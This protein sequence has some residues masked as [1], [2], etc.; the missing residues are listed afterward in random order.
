VK[1]VY[2]VDAET[3]TGTC[4]VLIENKERALIAN[5]A[6]GKFTI[7][8]LRENWAVVEAA[9]F[10]YSAGFF[11]TV[12]PESIIEVGKH[13]QEHGKDYG[14]NLSAPFLVQF[15]KDQMMSCLPYT[16]YLWGN[17]LEAR[18]FA[19][20]HELGTTDLTAIAKHLAALPQIGGRNRRVIITHGKKPTIVADSDGTSQEFAVELLD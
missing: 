12:S 6:A 2:Q 13:A 17:E 5:I 18:T 8:F 16:T 15:F 14:M 19:E 7:E 3:P 20:T 9:K 11:L 1:G 10:Y 4:A